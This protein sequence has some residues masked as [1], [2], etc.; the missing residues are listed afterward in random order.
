MPSGAQV[1]ILF[2]TEFFFYTLFFYLVIV[3]LSV[4]V[5]FV[6][7]ALGGFGFSVGGFGYSDECNS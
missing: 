3:R 6:G 1:R 7:C 5:V 4:F 2:L